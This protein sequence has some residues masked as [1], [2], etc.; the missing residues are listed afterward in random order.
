MLAMAVSSIAE[1]LE[2]SIILPPKSAKEAFSLR[3]AAQTSI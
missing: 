2:S 3:A 1:T